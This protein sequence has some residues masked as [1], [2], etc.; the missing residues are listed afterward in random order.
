M[1]EK[2]LPQASAGMQDHGTS[3]ENLEDGELGEPPE[4]VRA[5]PNEDWKHNTNVGRQLTQH[6]YYMAH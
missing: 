4:S 1:A 5:S 3:S 6:L 2:I